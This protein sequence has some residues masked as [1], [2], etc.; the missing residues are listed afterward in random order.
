MTSRARIRAIVL[1]AVLLAMVIAPACGREQRQPDANDVES[2]LGQKEMTLE[3]YLG[4]TDEQWFLTGKKRYTVQAMMVSRETSF[5]NDLEMV[6]YT[7]TDDDTTVIL[8]GT[9]GEMW[10]T[11]LS[12]VITTYTKPDGSELS[13]ADF[14]E[15]DAF[16]D[17]VSIPTPDSNFAMFV[18]QGI[19]VTVETAWGDVLHANLPTAP[20]GDGDYLVCRAGDNHEPDL[21]DVW[22]V[23]GV[24]FPNTYDTSQLVEEQAGA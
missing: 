1:I 9:A 20:H 15:K 6:D 3:E 11:D 4:T 18:P 14:A 19:A 2:T 23:N 22:I 5:H 10:A 21:S 16:I 24:I 8:K 7:V 12:K 13:K 17:I